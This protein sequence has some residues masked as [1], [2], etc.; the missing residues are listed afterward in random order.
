MSRRVRS[1][2]STFREDPRHFAVVVEQE[3]APRPVVRARLPQHRDRHRA[4]V[5]A[6][7]WRVSP[8]ATQASR[9]SPSVAGS[10][11]RET[12]SSPTSAARRQSCRGGVQARQGAE[13]PVVA[14]KDREAGLELAL[15]LVELPGPQRQVARAGDETT[16]PARAACR[17]AGAPRRA[18][19]AGAAAPPRAA[20]GARPIGPAAARRPGRP[21]SWPASRTAAR[22]P[23][24]VRARARSRPRAPRAAIEVESA[25]SRPRATSSASAKRCCPRRLEASTPDGFVVPPSAE[26]ERMR[27]R[28]PPPGRG[29]RCRRS[30][31]RAGDR[32][33]RAG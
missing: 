3:E 6:R 21:D 28:S 7:P 15:G 33:P 13:Q 20:R 10:S 29:P 16:R 2:D 18:P 8:S 12:A 19:G 1:S 4:V 5:L 23:R 31:G 25:A 30:H 27:A 22:P 9:S 11:A 14:G 32:V 24:S 17:G 26:R